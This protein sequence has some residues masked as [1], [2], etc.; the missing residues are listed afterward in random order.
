ME[1]YIL[2][3]DKRRYKKKYDNETLLQIKHINKRVETFLEEIQ[4]EVNDIKNN[5]T[6]FISH[7]K[8]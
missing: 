8:S 7:Q 2:E 4:K 3:C 5:K 6:I 1:E